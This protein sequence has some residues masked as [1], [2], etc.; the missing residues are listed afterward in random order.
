MHLD[1]LT[2]GQNSVADLDSQ[3][4]SG[5]QIQI[6]KCQL[7]PDPA[8]SGSAIMHLRIQSLNKNHRTFNF[9]NA[10]GSFLNFAIS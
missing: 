3:P 2:V 4:G 8:G 1:P 10:T 7:S 9:V 6:R 5:F